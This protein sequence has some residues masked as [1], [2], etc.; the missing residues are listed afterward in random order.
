MYYTGINPD[1]MQPI[2]VPKSKKEKM[3]QRALMQYGKPSNYQIVRD[4][5]IEAGRRDLI[6]YGEH[7]LIRPE[8]D[9]KPFCKP[10]AHA[11]KASGGTAVAAKKNKTN[12]DKAAAKGGRVYGGNA[13]RVA[14]KARKTVAGKTFGHGKKPRR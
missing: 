13:G 14:P 2:Y 3:M 6:G 9:G 8:G 10:A 11:F 5:L 1:T 7:C 4:A 12:A